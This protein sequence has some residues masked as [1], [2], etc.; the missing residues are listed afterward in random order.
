MN[1]NKGIGKSRKRTPSKKH[2]IEN[3]R[4]SPRKKEESNE[5]GR[6]KLDF[7]KDKKR[8]KDIV[9]FVNVQNNASRQKE[10]IDRV[11][12][13]GGKTEE[14]FD[15]NVKL[16][17]T[18][19]PKPVEKA[20]NGEQAENSP[21][22]AG[23]PSPSPQAVLS[24][25]NS[26]KF[27]PYST[28]SPQMSVEAGRRDSRSMSRSYSL[29][30]KVLSNR[31]GAGTSNVWEKAKICG[32]K[33]IS[34]DE[35]VRKYMPR[36]SNSESNMKALKEKS[37]TNN[38]K[39]M[40]TSTRIVADVKVTKST[41]P[42]FKIEDKTFAFRPVLHEFK[43]WPV[44]YYKTSLT[45][46]PFDVPKVKSKSKSKSKVKLET[47]KEQPSSKDEEETISLAVRSDKLSEEEQVQEE[48]KEKEIT[49]RKCDIKKD[50]GGE[51]PGYCDCCS[52]RYKDLNKHLRSD[53]HRKFARDSNNFKQLDKLI[54]QGTNFLAFVND[55]KTIA[56]LDHLSKKE[57]R[58]TAVP[59]NKA[60]TKYAS[61]TKAQSTITTVSQAS[62]TSTTVS[63]LP[64]P[65]LRSPL[66]RNSPSTKGA[67]TT[68]NHVTEVLTQQQTSLPCSP[69][70]HDSP[71][72]K[73]LILSPRRSPRINHHFPPPT[74]TT[75]LHANSPLRTPT[76]DASPIKPDTAFSFPNVS[77]PSKL[78]TSVTAL[79]TITSFP[80]VSTPAKLEITTTVN[81]PS[82]LCNVSNISTPLDSSTRPITSI[83]QPP[84]NTNH[85][86]KPLKDCSVTDQVK[87]PDKPIRKVKRTR[88]R[89]SHRSS[90]LST[91]DTQEE[92]ANE[93]EDENSPRDEIP[94]NNENVSLDESAPIDILHR[95]SNSFYAHRD[96][97][98]IIFNTKQNPILEKLL[99]PTRIL[100]SQVQ[101]VDPSKSVS[102]IIRLDEE[103]TK[104]DTELNETDILMKSFVDENF[105]NDEDKY[106]KSEPKS[107]P[108]LL[109]FDPETD[110]CVECE[111]ENCD[112][113][114]V[115]K[116]APPEEVQA[117]EMPNSEV[118]PF[119]LKENDEHNIQVKSL[120][121][122]TKDVNENRDFETVPSPQC[123]IE[124]IE[125][126]EPI[127]V[128]DNNDVIKT[129]EHFHAEN[130]VDQSSDQEMFEFSD[131]NVD[132][133]D[134]PNNL[135]R[136]INNPEYEKNLKKLNAKGVGVEDFQ[137]VDDIS[138]AIFKQG[139][140]PKRGCKTRSRFSSS[141]SSKQQLSPP[142][143][144]VKTPSKRLT[145]KDRQA[146]SSPFSLRQSP[147]LRKNS[148][149][150]Q[151]LPVTSFKRN[152]RTPTK[153]VEDVDQ[154][155]QFSPFKGVLRT[156]Q[157]KSSSEKS[158]PAVSFKKR[159]ATTPVTP[160]NR[161]RSRTISC[162][163][164]PVNHG[165]EIAEDAEV[166]QIEMDVD[167]TVFEENVKPPSQ[168]S[169]FNDDGVDSRLDELEQVLLSSG[170][171]MPLL[172]RKDSI[173]PIDETLIDRKCSE[174]EKE[175]LPKSTPPIVRKARSRSRRTDSE[176]SVV[177]CD[178]DG[179][180]QQNMEFEKEMVLNFGQSMFDRIKNNRRSSKT[181]SVESSSRSTSPAMTKKRS[182]SEKTKTTRREIDKAGA[183]SEMPKPRLP[184]RSSPRKRD[185]MLSSEWTS[186]PG[187]S[188]DLKLTFV[189][190]KKTPFEKPNV[191]NKN[192]SV[193]DEFE[194]G[195]DLQTLDDT[196]KSS[197]KKSA[198]KIKRVSQKQRGLTDE[199]E[200][201]IEEN[202][203]STIRPSRRCKSAVS[204]GH[205]CDYDTDELPSPRKQRNVKT[206]SKKKSN[207]KD[208]SFND[209]VFSETIVDLDNT[210]SPKQSRRSKSASKKPIDNDT[211][212]Y[213]ES[214][215]QK[216][217]NKSKKATDK[218]NEV[219]V[220]DPTGTRLGRKCKILSKVIYQESVYDFDDHD[221]DFSDTQRFR[222]H[223]KTP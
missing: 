108:C 176:R 16:V 73:H 190:K 39:S 26:M 210:I 216:R 141:T 22:S 111:I 72:K 50:G 204:R 52:L 118:V 191:E 186:S 38:A 109:G 174:I 142:V 67:P 115:L 160:S 150:E 12:A 121:G 34:A 68:N 66:K 83:L 180:S 99:T 175:T 201:V 183:S 163:S 120:D 162:E 149:S 207:V 61:S 221:V 44:I 28:D 95:T 199:T 102:R 143:T 119:D 92:L 93:N 168:A 78:E 84:D 24:N 58:T 81:S 156:R 71:L 189:K 48:E 40:S 80:M 146:I 19:V 124:Q 192:T 196:L 134:Q 47:P 15:R 185:R 130:K 27:S 32:A 96:D 76:L 8:L 36:K 147:R 154:Y 206:C 140:T 23:R 107:E 55:L 125:K 209:G 51:R 133:N 127:S 20:N 101:P 10:I 110:G 172:P 135:S 46:T 153:L 69:I 4:R 214:N 45:Q 11:I 167:D 21:L 2:G 56:K 177:S 171:D 152:L 117:D 89:N 215:R 79:S 218:T 86:A 112:A 144:N 184:T 97:P 212:K 82:R 114:H 164:L 179:V 193:L 213:S 25:K 138:V 169:T 217:D 137:L 31:K 131:E 211:S 173:I 75:I 182:K 5:K 59:S 132:E 126:Q 35:F 33:V 64:L 187:H 94:P 157:K 53:H 103:T 136:I 62:T 100:K 166:P 113:D 202:T 70:K 200:N 188:G 203:R 128:N 87:T 88:K 6:R 123:G 158:Q 116:S 77:S 220:T 90:Q 7:N 91:I 1:G 43:E 151:S 170:T 219:D 161:K 29:M 65:R 60:S 57:T 63:K 106:V 198:T 42:C 14:F 155:H 104:D 105:S 49:K 9:V 54:G 223:K 205:Y 195:L 197:G 74:A 178:D 222:R 159:R 3:L 122:E 145:T 41:P 194:Q 85:I 98:E 139:T 18:T 208:I 37:F 148:S 181:S 165:N 129:N 13:L 30:S 17:V